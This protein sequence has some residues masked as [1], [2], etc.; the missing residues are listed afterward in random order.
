[1]L[2]GGDATLTAIG[3][4]LAFCLRVEQLPLRPPYLASFLAVVAPLIVVRVLALRFFGVYRIAVRHIAVRDALVLFLSSLLGTVLFVV[5]LALDRPAPFPR[6]V[7]PIELLMSL[8]FLATLRYGARLAI[9]KLRGVSAADG[10]PARRI[11]ILGAGARGVALARE[12]RRRAQEGM[13]LIGFLDDDP[14]KRNMLLHGAPVIGAVADVRRVVLTRGV[15]EVIIA[16]AAA[17]RADVR[18]IT[19]DCQDVPVRL[20][21]SPGFAELSEDTLFANLR[22]VSVEDV[23]GREPVRVSTAEIA[24]YL[25]GERVLVTGGGGS[26]GSELVRQIAAVR[27]A[28]LILLGH[29]ESSIF[30]IEQEMVRCHGIRPTC[31]IADT[32]DAA[33]LDCLMARHMPTVVFHA[34]AHKHVPLME[35]NPEEAITTNVGGTRNL[36]RAACRNGVSRFVMISTDKAVNPTSIMGASKR[37]AEMVV[38]AESD[39]CDTQFATVRFGNV[40]GSRGSV[41]P[42]MKKQIE[43]GGPVTVTHPDAVRYFMTIPEAVQL[44]I[45]AGALVDS[46]RIY[47]L[48]MGEPVRIM[49]LAHDLIRLS[50]LVPGKDIPIQVIGLRPGEKLVEELLTAEEGASVTRHERI[51]VAAPEKCRVPD[52]D[53]GVDALLAA[54]RHP[55]TAAMLRLLRELVPTYSGGDLAAASVRQRVV[56]AA[57]R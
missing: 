7:V 53:E 28:E 54:A 29:G 47:M 44:V 24:G 52:L 27:P 41:V 46:G 22:D 21:I 39:R 2:Y 37:M 31:L 8:F 49:D 55:D 23:L 56:A 14:G 34:A 1:M 19:R 18:A 10:L 36:A 38:N 11:L 48:D 33:R 51:F 43:Q 26:I 30:E 16:M 5:F 3:L 4:Y 6:T 25:A 50:G 17:R 40:L 42:L 32:R 12:I 9:E 57:G 45:Q 35:R 15:G 20:R 13:H